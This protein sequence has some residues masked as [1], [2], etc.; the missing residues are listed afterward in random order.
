MKGIRRRRADE[1]EPKTDGSE[2]IAAER[3][4]CF[5]Y[6]GDMRLAGSRISIGT[7]SYSLSCFE[8]KTTMN[9]LPLHRCRENKTYLV[10]DSTECRLGFVGDCRFA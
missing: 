1:T 8:L 9:M 3:L 7:P 2:D 5:K 6:G 10:R 4:D